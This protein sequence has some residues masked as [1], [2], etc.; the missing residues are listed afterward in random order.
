V[1]R[2]NPFTGWRGDVPRVDHLWQRDGAD[3]W[4]DGYLIQFGL[5]QEP[6]DVRATSFLS[7][8][9][10]VFLDRPTERQREWVPTPAP[11]PPPFPCPACD[12]RYA[13]ELCSVCDG[14]GSVTVAS[15]R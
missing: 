4:D 9:L 6:A 8:L 2:R 12:G 11:P 14:A 7:I 10:G 1:T 13:V 5:G 15:P 3:G